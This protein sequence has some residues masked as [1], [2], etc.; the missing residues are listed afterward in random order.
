MNNCVDAQNDDD[1]SYAQLRIIA[2]D[3]VEKLGRS[4]FSL[5]S[6][7]SLFFLFLWWFLTSHR[8]CRGAS[9]H[10]TEAIA[11]NTGGDTGGH[12]LPPHGTIHIV[13]DCSVST[14]RVH[15]ET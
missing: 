15:A 14:V 5:F 9:V 3:N 2:R 12:W 8:M 10:A 6:S 13:G 11:R 7:F 4:D 1:K